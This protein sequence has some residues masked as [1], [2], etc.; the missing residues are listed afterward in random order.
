MQEAAQLPL[1]LNVFSAVIA[2]RNTFLCHFPYFTQEKFHI[3]T[4]TA[5]LY[6]YQPQRHLTDIVYIHISNADFAYSY[7]L[8][9]SSMFRTDVNLDFN[10]E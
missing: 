7:I 5:C 4:I 9:S 1:F 3:I 8:G 6:S 10:T 2:T